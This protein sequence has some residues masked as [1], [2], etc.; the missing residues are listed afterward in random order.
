MCACVCVCV[1]S[2][3]MGWHLHGRIICRCDPQGPANPKPPSLLLHVLPAAG[4]RSLILFMSMFV[5]GCLQVHS[6]IL[7]IA[8]GETVYN[9]CIVMHVLALPVVAL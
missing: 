5:V 7:G 9:L 2:V 4:Y 8:Q 1:C 6:L 3:E